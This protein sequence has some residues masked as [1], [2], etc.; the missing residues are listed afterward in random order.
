MDCFT[1]SYYLVQYIHVFKFGVILKFCIY[2]KAGFEAM[3]IV[4]FSSVG[5]LRCLQ[6]SYMLTASA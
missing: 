2:L 5:I 6:Y 4:C 1:D 3:G